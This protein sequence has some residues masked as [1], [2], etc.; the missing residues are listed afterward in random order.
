MAERMIILKHLLRGTMVRHCMGIQR[1]VV[2]HIHNSR[3]H[4][5]VTLIVNLWGSC[6]LFGSHIHVYTRVQQPTKC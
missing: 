6:L 2:V 4:V 5:Y 1:D 3:A